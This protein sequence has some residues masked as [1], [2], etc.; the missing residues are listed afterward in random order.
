MRVI[1]VFSENF[2]IIYLYKAVCVIDDITGKKE[3]KYS[4]KT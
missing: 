1:G 2:S 3:E 4:R